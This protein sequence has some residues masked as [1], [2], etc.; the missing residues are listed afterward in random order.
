VVEWKPEKVQ[1]NQE[2]W[3]KENARQERR[4]INS[5]EIYVKEDYTAVTEWP[6]KEESFFLDHSS[7]RCHKLGADKR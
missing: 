7:C 4:A 5:D 2:Q 1:K 3:R 6:M